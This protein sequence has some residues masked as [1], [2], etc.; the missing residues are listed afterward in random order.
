[1]FFFYFRASPSNMWRV[2]FNSDDMYVN[3]T[4]L[5]PLAVKL[6]ELEETPPGPP[7]PPHQYHTETSEG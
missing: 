2:Y 3:T 6:S 4:S 7:S 1:M 5:G